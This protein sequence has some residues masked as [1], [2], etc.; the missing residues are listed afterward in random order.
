MYFVHTDPLMKN[1]CVETQYIPPIYSGKSVPKF[2]S[3]PY[4]E[5]PSE[6]DSLPELP[7]HCLTNLLR[8]GYKS[9]YKQPE[10][11]RQYLTVLF[12]YTLC[13]SEYRATAPTMRRNDWCDI[14]PLK[15]R[16]ILET[17]TRPIPPVC[18]SSALRGD[19]STVKV[20][21]V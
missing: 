5:P 19:P 10:V 7:R 18:T 11:F 17:N 14:L 1:L 6:C 8:A 4:D 20:A 12:I 3:V 15:S 2:G 21:P 16:A 9:Y 13:L